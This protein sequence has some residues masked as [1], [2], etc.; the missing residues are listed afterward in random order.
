[1]ETRRCVFPPTALMLLALRNLMT[2][3]LSNDRGSTFRA[4]KRYYNRAR[5]L[6]AVFTGCAIFTLILAGALVTSND[7][8]LSVPD[9]P[10]SFGSLYR[11][12]PMVGG[13]RFEHGHRMLAE[14]VG[15]LTIILALWTWRTDERQ[16]M[17]R[18]SI[19]ALA[20][21]I[22]Q[23]ILG[24]L[25]V[26]YFLPPAVS[27]AHAA[28]GQT[29][30][31]IT[32]IIA[33]FTGRGAAATPERVSQPA[34]RRIARLALISVGVLYVQL[35]LGGLFRHGGM[36]WWPHVANSIVVVA[37]LTWTTFLA[38][39]NYKDADQIRK[40][41][42][43]ILILLMLQVCLGSAAFY[44]RV[45]HGREA[46]RP[47]LPMVISTVAHVG[48][49]ALLLATTVILTIRVWLAGL[50]SEKVGVKLLPNREI[51]GGGSREYIV[52]GH[53]RKRVTWVVYRSPEIED[54]MNPLRFLAFYL[55]GGL[56]AM[57]AQVVASPTSTVPN[58]GASGAI[59]AVMGAF[60][61]TY[62]RD[63]MR[64]LLV[65]FVFVR[66]IFIP[67]ALL[68]VVWF[69]IQLFNAGAAANVQTGGVA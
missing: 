54:A 66:V 14:F 30:F 62:P 67:A 3:S 32:V 34:G 20:V 1:M 58:L 46:L 4:G 65:I 19:T 69:L 39:S 5:Y 16:W 49:G 50:Q 44:T 12:P 48:L 61:V 26:L 24:G 36:S 31:C 68:I 35:L 40:P 51:T 15:L 60:L 59:A 63:R 8:G 18:L 42:L 2:A 53:N 27:T 47:Q 13:V 56:V 38:L 28:L 52:A 37:M 17:R 10:T 45:L 33:T 6:F 11:I 23:G 43:L 9:W 57:L 41:A 21:V 25:T 55:A 7:A 29:F 64:S 22:M